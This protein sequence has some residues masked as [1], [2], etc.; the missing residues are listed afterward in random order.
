MPKLQY[1][2]GLLSTQGE[3]FQYEVKLDRIC[4]YYY[5]FYIQFTFLIITSA[6]SNIQYRT[7][8]LGQN[9]ALQ[10]GYFQDDNVRSQFMT[11]TTYAFGTQSPPLTH[12]GVGRSPKMGYRASKTTL[13]HSTLASVALARM[14][15][16]TTLPGDGCPVGV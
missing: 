1:L 3:V 7:T 13:K 10:K 2:N 15:I 16:A 4:T 6:T 12:S 8:S 5:S 14:V 9:S 11:E